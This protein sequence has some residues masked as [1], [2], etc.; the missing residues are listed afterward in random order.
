MY[1]YRRYNVK[2]Y[3]KYSMFFI[4]IILIKILIK[5][6]IIKLLLWY[7]RLN[8]SHIK[9]KNI[10][11]KAINDILTLKILYKLTFPLE[12][13]DGIHGFGLSIHYWYN[14]IVS[15]AYIREFVA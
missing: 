12:P 14:I 5:Y 2:I 6:Y 7:F 13:S 11:K 1:V 8:A 9:N 4:Q 15:D 10:K 3:Y